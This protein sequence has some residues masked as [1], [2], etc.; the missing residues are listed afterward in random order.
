WFAQTA[1]RTFL[2]RTEWTGCCFSSACGVSATPPFEVSGAVPPSPSAPFLRDMMRSPVV[3]SNP[4]KD[5]C[6]DPGVGQ[7][8]RSLVAPP[9]L[10]RGEGVPPRVGTR[11]ETAARQL[12]LGGPSGSAGGG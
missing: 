3:G 1:A 6:H 8:H 5:P 7:R 10:L 11:S 9:P 12:G 2:S 4:A